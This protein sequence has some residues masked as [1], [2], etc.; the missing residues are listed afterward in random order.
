[1]K[2]PHIT[3]LLALAHH[4]QDLLDQGTVHDYADIARLSGLSRARVSQ[5]MNLTLLAAEIQEE[6]LTGKQKDN[7]KEHVLRMT[8]KTVVWKEQA[9]MW[10]KLET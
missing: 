6:I 3:R 5:I 7:L 1:N 10:G 8:L 4:L 2:L 9:V